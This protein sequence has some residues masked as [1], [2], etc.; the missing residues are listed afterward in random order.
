M[1]WE[2][3]VEDYE[4]E[5]RDTGEFNVETFDWYRKQHGVEPVQRQKCNVCG[6]FYPYYCEE[7][8][9]DTK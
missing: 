8:E 6:G 1:T 7:C 5:L 3:L 4:A 9:K 2:T